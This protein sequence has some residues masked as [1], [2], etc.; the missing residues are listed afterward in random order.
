MKRKIPK[1]VIV[2]IACAAG[3]A[4]CFFVFYLA[5]T[6]FNGAFVDWFEANFMFMHNEDLPEIGKEIVAR[7]LLWSSVKAL[8]L[9]VFVC[10][11]VLWLLTVFTASFLYA[12]SQ[13]KKPLRRFA[14]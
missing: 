12:R 9:T 7:D 11:V 2:L 1:P 14:G 3:A 13:V 6:Y 4:M 10:T 5:D 8:L